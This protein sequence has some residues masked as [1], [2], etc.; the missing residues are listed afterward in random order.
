MTAQPTDLPPPT[1]GMDDK[2]RRID[3]GDLLVLRN[4]SSPAS[5]ANIS[6]PARAVVIAPVCPK[7]HGAGRL[8]ADEADAAAMGWIILERREFLGRVR[9]EVPCTC[10]IG[11]QVIDDWRQMP[12]DA[13]GVTLESLFDLPDQDQAI[14]AVEAFCAAPRGWLTFGGD[15][16]VGKTAFLYAALNRLALQRRYG[17]Y[18]TAPELIDKLRNLIR[19][20]GD[21]DV[22]LDRWCAAPLIAIDE[23]DKYDATEFAEKSIFRLFNARYQRWA[24]SGTLL[25]YNLDRE[26]RLPPF[27]RSRIK[28][29]R[30]QF[31]RLAG[32]D[33]RP[34]LG[35]SDAWDQ[36]ESEAL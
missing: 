12:P 36:G 9:V 27:L 18:I 2:M 6:S 5:P 23:L 21:P 7:C 10:A 14:A 32:A 26:Q 19:A 1:D 25:A 28:D 31:I 22:Y 13:G 11:L 35:D 15:Y 20:G 16:G 24:T 4:V 17:R 33:V 8:L 34:A 3:P 29:G 30:F